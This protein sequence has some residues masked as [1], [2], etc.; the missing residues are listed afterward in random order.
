MATDKA[1]QDGK[2][3]TLFE[4]YLRIMNQSKTK[5]IREDLISEGAAMDEPSEASSELSFWKDHQRLIDRKTK[6]V[7]PTTIVIEKYRSLFEA[8]TKALVTAASRGRIRMV[9]ALL[10]K[11]DH[12]PESVT[13]ALLDAITR[14]PMEREFIWYLTGRTTSTPD[15]DTMGWLIVTGHLDIALYLARKYPGL[16]TTKDGANECPLE[17]L[18]VMKFHFHSG[19]RLNFWENFIYKCIP[20]CLVNTSYDNSKHTKTTRAL[21]QFK[22]SLWNLA[23]KPAPFIKR[24]GESKL[25]HKCSL[26]LANLA[27]IKNKSRMTTPENLEYLLTSGIVLDATSRGIS[28]I[29]NLCIV[30]FPEL[31]WDE[32]FIR[33]LMKEAVKGRHVELFLLVRAHYIPQL[34]PDYW[35]KFGLMKAVTKWSPRCE[36]PDV[37]GA[38]FLMQRE[39]QWFKVLEDSSIPCIKSL[40]WQEE[41]RTYWENIVEKRC[42]LVK[43]AGVWMKDT[44][45]SCSLVVTLIITIAFTAIFTVPGGN[46]DSTGNPIFLKNGSF[47]VFAVADAFALF[48]SV[49]ATLMFLAI[50]TSRYAIED[51]LLSLPRKMILGLTF[52]FLS[53]A[54]MLVAFSSALTVILSEKWKWIYIPIILLATLPLILFAIL[55]LPLYVQMVESTYRPRLYCSVMFGK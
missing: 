35:M 30:H 24:I 9:K 53:L 39:L 48:S 26:K 7:M 20:L 13:T 6:R 31:M 1:F 18:A 14:S 4:E 34:T 50:L 21:Q 19:A 43:E 2:K 42:N 49:T 27:L 17:D 8:A 46:N 37:S 25:R 54:F 47:M 55:N 52:L 29:V 16:A 36:S 41:K 10:D 38:A 15:S 33:K 12:D 44:S 23:T 3:P 32:R 11:V 40:K 5:E 28:E 45:K 51:F 22:M